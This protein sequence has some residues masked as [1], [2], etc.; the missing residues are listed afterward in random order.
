MGV[1]SAESSSVK[2]SAGVPGIFLF[3]A[4]SFRTATNTA[5]AATAAMP[6]ITD[7]TT[8]SRLLD[9]LEP[10][11][12]VFV[13]SR[14]CAELLPD[15]RIMFSTGDVALLVGEGSTVPTSPVSVITLSSFV[16]W[17]SCGGRVRVSTADVLAEVSVL[18]STLRPESLL[19]EVDPESRPEPASTPASLALIALPL[20]LACDPENVSPASMPSP[21]LELDREV[22]LSTPALVLVLLAQYSRP[23]AA[24]DA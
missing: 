3:L 20:L 4:R 21:D 13:V 15:G 18:E 7:A 5:T 23:E 12:E 9:Q 17:P 2:S 6:H 11:D 22:S 24:H 10:F 16:A 19:D 14:A 8:V 1:A